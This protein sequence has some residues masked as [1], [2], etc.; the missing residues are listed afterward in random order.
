MAGEMAQGFK[1][2]VQLL[3]SKAYES[4]FDIPKPM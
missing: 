1:A 3:A 4:D 2:T